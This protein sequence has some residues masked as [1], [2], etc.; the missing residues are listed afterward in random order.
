MKTNMTD[1]DRYNATIARN[2][3]LSTGM[4]ALAQFV[5]PD[6]D[7][8]AGALI[9]AATVIIERKVGRGLAPA[10]LH[11]LLAPTIADWAGPTPGEVRQ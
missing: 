7:E 9:T 4:L 5:T 11:A 6:L 3:Q 10:A 2:V 8:Q 1:R